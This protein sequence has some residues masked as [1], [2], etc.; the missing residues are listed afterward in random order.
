MEPDL[1]LE[2]EML[3]RNWRIMKGIPLG[4]LI[5]FDPSCER[6]RL[7]HSEQQSFD[8]DF[9]DSPEGVDKPEEFGYLDKVG[10]VSASESSRV[11]GDSN[12]E[13]EQLSLR[14]MRERILKVGEEDGS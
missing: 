10:S 13:D 6:V 8:D 1:R 11:G 14:G 5:W 12:S 4:M 2:H 7:Y 3:I 9:W